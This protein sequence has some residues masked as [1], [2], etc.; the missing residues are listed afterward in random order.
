MAMKT[1][2][3]KVQWHLIILRRVVAIYYLRLNVAMAGTMRKVWRIAW[4]KTLWMMLLC[5]REIPC[6]CFMPKLSR[7][8]RERSRA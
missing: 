1:K 6:R 7:N 4:W 3:M 2:R 8:T 5:I